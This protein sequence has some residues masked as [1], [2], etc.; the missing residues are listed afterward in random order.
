MFLVVEWVTA[1]LKTCSVSLEVDFS[2]VQVGPVLGQVALGFVT[3]ER[4]NSELRFSQFVFVVYGSA[5][6]GPERLKLETCIDPLC[7]PLSEGF[8]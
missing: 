4:L 2:I 5:A 6:V 3:R 7:L 8:M 1:A